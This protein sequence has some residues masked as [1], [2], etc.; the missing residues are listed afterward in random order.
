LPVALVDFD[1]VV[2]VVDEHRVVGDVFN[3]ARAAAALEVAA[4]FCGGV[5]PDFDA[6]AVGGVVHRG[7]ENV[8][9]LHNVI[10]A[11]ILSERANRDSVGT[12]T[13]HVLYEY[14][15]AVWLERY[16]IVS[17]VDNRILDHDIRA[18]ISVPTVS[19]L[20]NIHTVASSRNIDV[21]KDD[22]GSIGNEM[23]VLGRISQEQVAENGIMKT[24]DTDQDWSKGVDIR[25]IKIVPDL[26]IAIYGSTTVNIDIAAS[27]L[28]ERSHVLEDEFERM[29]LPVCSVVGELDI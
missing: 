11:N 28:P 26:S 6:G 23:V 17:I 12:V 25:G 1:R 27:P 8:D 7:I 18:S 15:R 13:P 21:V 24:I 14:V 2:N 10:L 5:G 4:E 9:V 22:I 16:A 3:H 19:V 29:S 20:G